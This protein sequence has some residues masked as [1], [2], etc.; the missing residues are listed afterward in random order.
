MT[1]RDP[2]PWAGTAV[3]DTD[4]Q[5]LTCTVCHEQIVRLRLGQ[6]LDYLLRQVDVHHILEHDF[7]TEEKP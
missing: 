5:Q 7:V 1:A 6:S 3:V 4:R 2:G